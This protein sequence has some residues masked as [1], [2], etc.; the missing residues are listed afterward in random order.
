MSS[1]LQPDPRPSSSGGGAA[2]AATAAQPRDRGQRSPGERGRIPR[3][4]RRWWIALTVSVLASFAVL[5][6]MGLRIDQEKPPIPATVVSADGHDG[7]VT[8]AFDRRVDPRRAKGDGAWRQARADVPRAD[9]RPRRRRR[10]RSGKDTFHPAACRDPA[11][12]PGAPARHPA[13]GSEG[14]IAR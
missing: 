4:D 2:P 10:G 3:V 6:F 14:I 13:H 8:G 12:G 11:R 7:L 5:L 1:A 9:R